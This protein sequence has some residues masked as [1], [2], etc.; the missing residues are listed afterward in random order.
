VSCLKFH[1]PWVSS[2]PMDR[3]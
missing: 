2:L 1:Y 3:Q